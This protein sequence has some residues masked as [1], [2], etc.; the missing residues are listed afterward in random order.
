MKQSWPIS[1]LRNLPK[2]TGKDYKNGR[3]KES[4][5][6][7]QAEP[8]TAVA[9]TSTALR[10]VTAQSLGIPLI[11]LRG[12]P[13]TNYF[14]TQTEPGRPF[15]AVVRS[16]ILSNASTLIPMTHQPQN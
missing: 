1:L 7:I 4:V 6:L 3:P 16:Q 5:P 10:P 13:H 14:N 15:P 12:L 9:Q 8:E 11:D 2:E